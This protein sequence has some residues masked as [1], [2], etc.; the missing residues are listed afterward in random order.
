MARWGMA[1]DLDRCVGCQACTVA[2]AVENEVPEGFFR[3]RVGEATVGDALPDLRL[4]FLHLQCYHCER[5]PCVPVCPTGATYV[6]RDGLCLVDYDLCI[7]CRACV[8]A[9]PYGMRYPHPRGFV[10]KCSLCDHRVTAGREPAC[11]ETCPTQA[12]VFGDL[13]DPRSPISR[14]LAAARRVEVDRPEAGTRPK[15]FFLNGAVSLPEAR[16]EVI[17]T[18][19]AGRDRETEV[20]R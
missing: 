9:C 18:S 19:A 8:V 13:D 11:V 20:R 2:C 6:T 7:G 17:P 14:A 1:V 3:R 10:D 12:L 5:P 16:E 4:T 15:F